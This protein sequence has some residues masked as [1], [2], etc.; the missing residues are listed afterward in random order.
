MRHNRSL[1]IVGRLEQ[2]LD[3]ISSGAYSTPALAKQLAVFQQTIYRDVLFLRRRGFVIRSGRLSTGWSYH[4]LAEPTSAA[5][6]KGS[7]GK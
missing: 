1:A 6:G 4:L 3:L 5:N 2:L 7:S